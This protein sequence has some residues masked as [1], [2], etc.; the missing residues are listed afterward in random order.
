MAGSKKGNKRESKKKLRMQKQRT[1][2]ES[3]Q[4]L[5]H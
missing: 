3:D 1:K 2:P 4:N 5:E